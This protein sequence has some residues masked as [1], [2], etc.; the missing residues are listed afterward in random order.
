MADND[1]LEGYD[2]LSEREQYILEQE[3]LRRAFEN[4]FNLITKRKKMTDI[5]N[6][7][8]GLILSH[9]PFADLLPNE[10]TNMM[11]FFVED[12]EY[13]KCAEVRDIIKKL[14]AKYA[15]KQKKESSQ[16]L[17]EVLNNVIRGTKSSKNRDS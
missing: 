3:L 15:R 17:S 1:P 16:E 11:D 10:L 5:V 12:E 9:D 7:S 6:E 13:E 14:K 4:S 2:D 8:G